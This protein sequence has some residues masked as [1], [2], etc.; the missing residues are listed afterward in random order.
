MLYEV[1]TNNSVTGELPIFATLLSYY[2]V[3]IVPGIVVEGDSYN[4][5]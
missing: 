4:F 3:D 5:V 2:G 1:I